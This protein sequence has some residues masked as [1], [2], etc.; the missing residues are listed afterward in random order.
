[1]ET[2]IKYCINLFFINDKQNNKQTHI[3]LYI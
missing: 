3:C 2:P 1:M